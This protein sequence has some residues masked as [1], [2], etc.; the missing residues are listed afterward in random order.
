MIEVTGISKSFRKRKVLNGVSFKLNKGEITALLGVNG[1]GKSTTL[2][3]IMGL[4]KQDSGK[5]LING[6]ELSYKNLDKLAFVPD[7]KNTFRGMKVK[8]SFEYMESFYDKWDS[9]RAYKMLEDFELNKDDKLDKLSKGSLAKVK[10]ILGFAQN[11][12][13]IIMDEPFSGID[14]FTREDILKSLISYISEERAIL[15]TTH[16]IGEIEGV[17]DRV[18]LLNE[19][20]I[21][22]DFYVEDMKCEE[23]VSLI[24]KMREVFLD[25]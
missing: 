13:Y 16:E 7:I 5:V 17:A 4:I 22:A 8:D 10:L 14:I 11:A 12:D 25:E 9:N 18:L 24:D 1:V 23:G 15:L 6:E 19:G 2:K 20:E 3:I 21:R